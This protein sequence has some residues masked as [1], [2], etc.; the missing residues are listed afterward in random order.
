MT[1]EIAFR[2]GGDML[3]DHALSSTD[4]AP[5]VFDNNVVRIC[6][7]LHGDTVVPRARNKLRVRRDIRHQFE[8]QLHPQ[9]REHA[10]CGLT[11]SQSTDHL[12]APPLHRLH[13]PCRANPRFSQPL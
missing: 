2:L 3:D 10:P 13:D 11:H 12:V 4:Q 7:F 6:A 1:F 8:I 9:T 5:I